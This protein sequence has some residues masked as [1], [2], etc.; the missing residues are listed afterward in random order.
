MV[1]FARTDGICIVRASFNLQHVLPAS[2]AVMSPNTF[3]YSDCFILL[4]FFLSFFLPLNQTGNS[5]IV[6]SSTC[7]GTMNVNV[8]I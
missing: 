2:P 5:H 6:F 3:V 4:P 7:Y 1:S 8:K